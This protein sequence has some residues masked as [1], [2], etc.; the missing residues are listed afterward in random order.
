MHARMPGFGAW[1]APLT[2]SLVAEHGM[3]QDE[4]FV[5][6]DK[7]D[8]AVGRMLVGLE[9]YGCIT[10]HGVGDEPPMAAFEAVG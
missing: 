3:P 10:C 7:A 9:G 5:A 4:A 1:A 8:A 6:T 2:T